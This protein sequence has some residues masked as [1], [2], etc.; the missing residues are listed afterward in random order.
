MTLQSGDLNDMPASATSR[1]AVQGI[2]RHHCVFA[3]AAFLEQDLHR[4][5]DLAWAL[6][7]ALSLVVRA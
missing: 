1:P 6:L 4:E 5:Q 3:W 2:D 7:S